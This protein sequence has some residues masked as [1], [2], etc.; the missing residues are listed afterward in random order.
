RVDDGKLLTI[1]NELQLLSGD[2]RLYGKAQMIQTHSGI[3]T[4]TYAGGS[5]SRD[6]QGTT[7]KFNFNY[8]SSP[9][10]IN[11]AS[12]YTLSAVLLDGTNPLNPQ[13]PQWTP[14][15]NGSAS[16]P[17]T[18]SK[19]WIFKYE[20]TTSSVANWV[21]VSNDGNIN[22][23][24]GFT[25]KGND[26]AG[27]FQNYTFKGEVFNGEYTIPVAPENL[28]LLGNP[29]P[30]AID[31]YAF[32]DDNEDVIDGT[33][34]FWDHFENNSTHVQ[35]LY[36]GGYASLTKV[37]VVAAVSPTG[38]VGTKFPKR[39]LPVGQGFMVF[40]NETGGQIM[41]KNSQRI[42]K[43]E[44][45]TDAMHLFR[46][47]HAEISEH[48]YL[49]LQLTMTD[50]DAI[51]HPILIGF[52]DD[53]A[54]DGY[55]LGYDA[56]IHK[57][58]LNQL[59]VEVD[60]KKLNILALG[61][62]GEEKI[63][64]LSI[65][66]LTSGLHEFDLEII[67]HP[68]LYNHVNYFLYDTYLNTWHDLSETKAKLNLKKDKYKHRFYLSFSKDASLFEGEPILRDVFYANSSQ[69]LGIQLNK[70]PKN[71]VEVKIYNIQGQ[72]LKHFQL[73]ADDFNNELAVDVLLNPGVY[74]LKVQIDG[75]Q[76]L[77]KFFVK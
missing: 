6:Q 4:N 62:F 10:G 8:W 11:N 9:V 69:Q 22:P 61:S 35:H 23:G 7:N 48:N 54:D 70:K 21:Y 2:L 39:Y 73:P 46:D 58:G 30:S 67:E 74:I 38:V 20:N 34:Y 42:F 27:S 76:H 77:K 31:A 64:P 18:I 52:M 16:S 50:S 32:I 66:V 45:D 56:S 55:N 47:E 33:L 26:A 65:D 71:T 41:F 72:A 68:E 5:L 53:L 36:E 12:N 29:Y 51:N 28:N 40:G 57:D 17:I 37:G 75:Q 1:K 14:G 24:L 49:K 19:R 15:V 63:I 43:T 59:Y 3:N 25:M 13:P 60:Q 44:D